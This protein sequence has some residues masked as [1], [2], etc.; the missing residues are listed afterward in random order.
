MAWALEQDMFKMDLLR[1]DNM[2]VAHAQGENP[3][4]G[5]RNFKL[6]PMCKWLMKSTHKM[7]V[8]MHE[9]EWLKGFDGVEPMHEGK[10]WAERTPK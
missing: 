5:Y 6:K 3:S 8:G 9:M 1:S 7:N 2:N 4:K 10:P